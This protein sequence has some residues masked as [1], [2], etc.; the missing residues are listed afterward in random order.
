MEFLSGLMGYGL[1]EL[2]D[3]RH[4][5]LHKFSLCSHS[6]HLRGPKEDPLVF[7]SYLEV[8]T[9]KHRTPFIFI[10]HVSCSIYVVLSTFQLLRGHIWEH[11]CVYIYNLV[12]S[13]D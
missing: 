12:D 1:Q 13:F 5:E 3:T 2:S 6:G 11:N 7:M 4:I 10:I 8:K 9:M